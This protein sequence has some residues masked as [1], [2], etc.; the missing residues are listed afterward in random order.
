M[1]GYYYVYQ[2]APKYQAQHLYSQSRV[3]ALTEQRKALSGSSDSATT[4]HLDE[5][6]A[7]IARLNDQAL[8][9]HRRAQSYGDMETGNRPT[10]TSTGS[11]STSS[12]L[13]SLLSNDPFE[14]RYGR[15]YLRGVPYPLPVDLEEIQRQNLRTMLSCQIFGKAVCAPNATKVIPKKVLEIGC[16]SA[17]WTSLCHEYFCS[18][19]EPNVAFTGLDIAPLAPD[20]KKEGV[21]WTFVQHD[22]RKLPLPF[23][24]EE[25]DLVMLKD[26]SLV[27]PLGKHSQHFLDESMRILAEGGTLEIWESDHT[28]R[29]LSPHSPPPQ[30]KMRADQ[31]IADSTA[32]FLIGLGTPFTAAQNKYLASANNWISKALDEKK[33]PPNPCARIAQMLY[34]EPETLADVGTLRIAIPLGELKWER[35]GFSNSRRDSYAASE[36]LA[37][38]GKGKDTIKVLTPDQAA[39][40]HTAL[41]TVL[42]HIESLEPLL[43]E[44]CGKNTEEW[45]HWWASMLADLLD[46]R[47]GALTGECLEVGAWWATKLA[48]E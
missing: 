28:V 16:S 11:S 12:D 20:L 42:Q 46:P 48:E 29:S 32:T 39:L 45:S 13:D 24:D 47:K 36:L 15:R 8:P 37:S 38:R 34:Q 25:F 26:L 7:A 31:A 19:G 14:L 3:A 40:R 2:A 33:L 44:A 17:Y 18:L 4:H 43:K 35:D 9:L 5:Q 1:D 27:V 41:L 21:N 22:I 6:S 30:T 10:T 23:D